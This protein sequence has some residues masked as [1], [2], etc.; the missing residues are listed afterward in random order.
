MPVVANGSEAAL[1]ASAAAALDAVS[2]FHVTGMYDPG[3]SIDLVASGAN[4][5]GTITTHGA[6]WQEIGIDGHA[7]LRGRALWGATVPGRAAELGDQWV[8]VDD[9][10]AGYQTA[11]LGANIRRALTLVVFGTHPGLVN[12]GAVTINGRRA[13]E[14][15]SAT[16]IYDIADDGTNYPLRWLDTN[17]PAA[18]GQPC[19]V[20]LTD[21]GKPV[22]IT[23]PV[24]TATLTP[25]PSPAA[26][27]AHSPTPSS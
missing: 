9:P 18:N 12:T 16:D 2:S 23:A 8:A 11:Q 19:G 4:T 26:S 6:T 14:L 17:D 10:N 15:H 24:A 7:Y 20:T 27:A 21:F 1:L 13:I 5:Q 25:P 3:L 22:T